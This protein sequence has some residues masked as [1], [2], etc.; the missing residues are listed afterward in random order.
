MTLREELVKVLFSNLL[1][2]AVIGGI[3]QICIT[4]NC[5]RITDLYALN[6]SIKSY[7]RKRLRTS[8]IFNFKVIHKIL[9][10]HH[11]RKLTNH[12]IRLSGD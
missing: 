2:K 1:L 5:W 9:M 3:S 11:V 7:K 6:Y 4:W 8:K 10:I 12:K